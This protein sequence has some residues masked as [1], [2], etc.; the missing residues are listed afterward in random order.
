MR[1][2]NDFLFLCKKFHTFEVT[3]WISSTLITGL[4]TI[5]TWKC[6][7]WGPVKWLRD[8][9]IRHITHKWRHFNQ[10]LLSRIF[11]WKISKTR[12]VYIMF[13]KKTISLKVL[14]QLKI[15]LQGLNRPRPSWPFHLRSFWRCKITYMHFVVQELF[16]QIKYNNEFCNNVRSNNFKLICQR[17]PLKNS[18]A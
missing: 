13:C 17:K 18:V 7:R 5:G 15:P 2:V 1:N 8:N 11:R 4:F 6:Q 14:F 3:T 9:Q 10:L 12:K 16:A